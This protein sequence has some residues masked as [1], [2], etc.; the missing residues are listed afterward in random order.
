LQPALWG[1]AH[2]PFNQNRAPSARFQPVHDPDP[3][4]DPESRPVI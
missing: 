2:V 3:I 1:R 4:V